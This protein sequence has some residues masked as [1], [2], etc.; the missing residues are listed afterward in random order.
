[1]VQTGRLSVQIPKDLGLLALKITRYVYY[2]HVSQNCVSLYPPIS[3]VFWETQSEVQPAPGGKS[4]GHKF[5]KSQKHDENMAFPIIYL[6]NKLAAIAER[7]KDVKSVH[8]I[9]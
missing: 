2:G 5:K 1:M 3:Q 8:K 4:H 7:K 6:V 9:K